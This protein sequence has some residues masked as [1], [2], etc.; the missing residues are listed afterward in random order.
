ML[1]STFG[2][3]LTLFRVYGVDGLRLADASVMPH[4]ISGPLQATCFMIGEKI[5][6]M[7]LDTYS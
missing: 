5:A 7:I 1:S 4:I 2:S 3:L 6:A